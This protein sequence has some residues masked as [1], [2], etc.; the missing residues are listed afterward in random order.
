MGADSVVVILL[1]MVPPMSVAAFRAVDGDIG[2]IV[3][4][5]DAQKTFIGQYGIAPPLFAWARAAL[6]D[7]GP[8]CGV[9]R[10]N[11]RIVGEIGFY[12]GR[13]LKLTLGDQSQSVELAQ[14]DIDDIVSLFGGH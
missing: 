5:D 9:L 6:Q 1:P 8:L 14:E 10:D 12:P 3:H 7:D 2:F 4:A 13:I 11:R